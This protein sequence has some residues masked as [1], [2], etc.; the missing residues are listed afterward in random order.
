[1]NKHAW[2]IR[3]QGYGTFDF[4]GTEVEAEEMRVHKARWE[5]GSSL[6]W[7]TDPTNPVDR[8]TAEIASDLD[9][10]KGIHRDKLL[11]LNKLKMKEKA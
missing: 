9:E 7:K 2:K 6:K 10:G 3:V 11:L 5:R 8:L 4:Y 1:M